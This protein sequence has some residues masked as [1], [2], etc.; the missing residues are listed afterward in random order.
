MSQEFS[1]Q[2]IVYYA[3][4]ADP[5]TVYFIPAAPVSQR[6]ANGS[7][8]I[9]LF[10]L[11]Q[12]AMLQLSSQWEVPTNQLEALK[13]AVLQ[14]FPALK[15][16][17]LQLLPAPVEV[18]RVELSLSNAAGKPECLGTTKSSG[19]PPFSAI[20]SVQLSNEQKAQAVSAFNGRKDLLTVTYYAALPKQAIAEVAI[21]GNV[22]PLLKRLPKDA[23]VQDC[24]EQLEAAI[25]QNQ[26]VLTRSQ[27]PN[28]SESLRQKAEQ[29]AKER[30]A[31]LLQQLAQGS[32]VQN[33]SEFCATAAV[34]DS[35][36]MSLTRSADINSWFLNGNG[37]DY[38]Q[39][40][41]A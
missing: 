25:A 14:Q 29:L 1:Y 3:S 10:V 23:S 30:A 9:S 32:T 20:F 21:S 35:V 34:T 31:K 22:T 13:T 37:L 11:D 40:F 19:Y 27:S 15:L 16:E 33:Q 17:S 26:L 2:G 38:L 18:E 36:P 39:L 7:L 28:A 8:A 6:N 41:S 5:A 4:D 24:L 12:M